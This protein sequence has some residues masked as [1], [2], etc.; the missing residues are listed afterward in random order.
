MFE[1]L[2]EPRMRF[3]ISFSTSGGK[4]LDRHLVSLSDPTSFEADQ[5]RRLRL[6]VEES[7]RTQETF[8]LAITSAITGEGK[9]LTAINLAGALAH[10]DGI[11]VLLI[12][13]D[14]RHP[15]IAQRLRLQCPNGGFEAAL[16]E[17]GGP[18][19]DF[20]EPIAGL[21]LDVLPCAASCQGSYE[22]LTSSRLAALVGEARG[23]YNYIILDTPPII[24]VPDS[25]LVRPVVDRYI[26]V[27]SASSTPR[28]LVGEALNLLEPDSLLGLVFNRDD[29]PLFGYYGN[30]RSYFRSYVQ[31]LDRRRATA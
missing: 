20:V 28:K 4:Q 29:H 25:S 7:G 17:P 30:Y 24:P 31:S 19:Q 22:L 21:N 8:V 6:R 9:T 5:Y 1:T 26:L 12:D 27:V 18:L 10:R 11:R 15:S 13:A 23:R 2:Q 16:R 14:L 3:R